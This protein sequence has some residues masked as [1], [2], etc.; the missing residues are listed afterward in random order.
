MQSPTTAW[1]QVISL[2]LSFNFLCKI[3]VPFLTRTFLC[4]QAVAQSLGELTCSTIIRY[5]QRGVVSPGLLTP[6]PRPSP[7]AFSGLGNSRALLTRGRC[8]PQQRLRTPS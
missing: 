8:A 1:Y 7:T 5:F 2:V 3:G 6:A 4:R